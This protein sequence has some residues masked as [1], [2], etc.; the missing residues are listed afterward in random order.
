MLKTKSRLD[1]DT[2]L[3]A[4]IDAAQELFLEE[5]FAAASMSKIAARLGGSKGTLYNYFKSKDDLFKA[6]VERS[7]LWQQN[8]VFAMQ[9]GEGPAEALQRIARS[10]LAHVLD[11]TTLRNFAVIAAESRR[12]PEIGRIFYEAG[13]RQGTEQL[14]AFLAGLDAAGVLDIEGDP[15][16]A[17]EHLLGL[18]QMPT[19]KGRLCNATPPLTP[20]QIDAE[21]DR[22]VK[23]F[24]KAFVRKG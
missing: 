19:F 16:G 3:E 22:G 21:A 15:R 20:Q 24:L 18:V 9:S 5:G 2:R 7:S 1:P 17:A 13:P 12:T 4:I 14:A 8:Q 23:T 6:Y 11:E 10:F